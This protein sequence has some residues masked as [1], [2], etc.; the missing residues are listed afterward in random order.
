M[1]PASGLETEM[2]VALGSSSK[3]QELLI[4]E[5]DEWCRDDEEEEDAINGSDCIWTYLGPPPDMNN[6]WSDSINEEQEER[7][8][9]CAIRNLL[10]RS[11]EVYRITGSACEAVDEEQSNESRVVHCAVVFTGRR[12]LG[13]EAVRDGGVSDAVTLAKIGRSRLR[14]LVRV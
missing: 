5:D 12:G 6:R 4:C 1:S 13:N 2:M 11:T 3:I 8:I 7:I 10:Q 9:L 14:D